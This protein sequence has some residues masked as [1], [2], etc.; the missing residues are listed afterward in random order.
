M[1]TTPHKIMII[2][3]EASGEQHGAA[4]VHAL[5]NKQAHLEFYGAGGRAMQTAGVELLVNC[6][7]LAVMGF[8]DILSHLPRL[9]RIFQQ[10]KQTLKT[11]RPDLLILIDYAGFNL[12]LAAVAKKLGIKVLFYISPKVW[13]WK[14][15]RIKKIAQCVDHLAV[16]FPFEVDCYRSVKLPVTYVGN[17]LTKTVKSN[18]TLFEARETWGLPKEGPVI[19]LVPGSRLTEIQR[20]LPV[21]LEAA[22][23]IK[24][25]HPQAHF[26]LPLASTIDKSVL[27][28]YLAA[29]WLK[30][31]VIEN[32]SHEAMNASD[33]L[34]IASGTATLEAALLV[35]PMVVIYKMPFFTAWL[36]RQVIKIPNVALCN[37]V[38]GRR[39]VP[40]LLQEALT[41]T[42]LS[43]A[44]LRILEDKRYTAQM[45]QDLQSVRAQ[46]GDLDGSENTAKLA[47]QM[48]EQ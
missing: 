29:S 34:M 20:L 19:G 27:Q 37:I 15:G 26:I 2:A 11:R 16:I 48:L 44:T 14:A 7:D 12:R 39:I 43:E 45:I 8:G 33:V 25:T 38:A 21:M 30:V 47:L 13:A 36:A 17:P 41:A 6:K 23:K 40:E 32:Q 22:E 42:T 9:W 28:A 46:L 3:G 31:T 4:L 1:K 18:L 24:L 5:Q 10:L 35:K